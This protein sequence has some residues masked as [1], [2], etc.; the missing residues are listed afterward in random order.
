[1]E[2]EVK[3]E[4]VVILLA[5]LVDLVVAVGPQMVEEL[6]QVLL[7]TL[8]QYRHHKEIMVAHQLMLVVLLQIVVE[9]E[10]ELEQ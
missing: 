7:E 4:V 10:E 6:T 5:P 1:M 2:V 8:H 9:E 3:L